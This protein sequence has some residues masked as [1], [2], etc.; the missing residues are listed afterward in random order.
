MFCLNG[1]KKISY[2]NSDIHAWK[3]ATVYHTSS[4]S[5]STPLDVVWLCEPL[6]LNEDVV[7]NLET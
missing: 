2:R 1:F 6:L 5:K 7:E 4:D 3:K